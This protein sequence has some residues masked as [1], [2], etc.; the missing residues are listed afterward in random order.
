VIYATE[1]ERLDYDL[2]KPIPKEVFSKWEK[3]SKTKGNIIDPLEMIEEYGTDAVRMALCASATQARQI[4]LDRRRFEE[5]K[6]FANKIWN[7]ARFVLLNLE[8]NEAQGTGALDV[9]EFSQGLDESLFALED[10]W[11]LSKLNRTIQSVNRHLERYEFDQAALEAYDFFWKE[12]CAYYVEI[13]KPVLFGKTGTRQERTNKQMLLVIVLCQTIRLMH[14]MAPFITEEIFH[15]L[16]ERFEGIELLSKAD[17]Y[18]KDCI[19]ALLSPA[20]MVSPFPQVVR[21][22]DISAEAEEAFALMEQVI[23]TIRNI[24]GEMKVP[25]SVA[26]D[27]YMTGK[28]D[29]RDWQ[30]VQENAHMIAP[31]VKTQKI[32]VQTVEPALGFVCTGACRTLK[33]ILPLPEE[34]LKQEVLRLRKEQERLSSS[35]DKLRAQLANPEF[36]GKAPAQLIEKQRLQLAHGEKELQEISQKL[37]SLQESS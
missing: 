37:T 25:P 24:R 22:A 8:E 19:Q 36:V 9:R 5:F 33:I 27:V 30:T 10:R 26:T 17:P 29:D 35:L 4:D 34:L 28:A 6:N 11:I 12:Y 18:T 16:K 3:M 23:Y 14:P 20:C 21:E 1:Q 32:S 31:L 2:G 13:S 7:G 15:I